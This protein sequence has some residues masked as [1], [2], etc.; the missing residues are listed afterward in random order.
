MF[1]CESTKKS[2]RR[3]LDLA[4]LVSMGRGG[5]ESVDIVSKIPGVQRLTSTV[6]VLTLM[7]LGKPVRVTGAEH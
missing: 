7:I 5:V 4:G 3:L 2:P 1:V 6:L